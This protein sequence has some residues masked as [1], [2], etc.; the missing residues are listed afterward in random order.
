M[1]RNMDLTKGSITG[2]MLLF[3][4]PM[5]AGNLLQQCY[6]LADTFIVGRCLGPEA[7]AAVGSSYS[8]MTFLLSLVIG[9]CMGSSTLFSM[10]FGNGDIPGLKKAVFTSFLLIGVITIAVTAVTFA[11]IDPII[12]LLQVPAEVHDD[13]RD[14]L[15]IICAG[16]PFTFLYN[17]Y[18]FLLR[19]VGDSVSPLWFLG[20]SV[21]LNIGLD[22]A[23]ILGA[24]AGTAGAALATVI[25]QAFSATG[26]IWW[27]RRK[28]S[29]L[30]TSRK[31]MKTD[32]AEIKAISSYSLLTCMQ[33]S[34]MNFGILMVQG[35][36]NSFG[37]VVMAAFATAVK[38]D[39]F[40]YMPL[41]EFGNAFSTF[42]AQN[43][44][45]G[46]QERIRKGIRSAAL[47][48]TGFSVLISVATVILAP[49]L[50]GIFVGA[51][52]TEVISVGT[53]YLRIEGSFYIGIG[54]LFMLYGLF[55][56]TGRPGFSLVLTVISLGLRVL[57]SY[58]LAP[59]CGVEWIWWAIPIGWAAA[60]AAGFLRYGFP[61]RRSTVTGKAAGRKLS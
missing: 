56:A 61:G 39:A 40:A 44:G 49:M 26:L 50:M 14:Y 9:L 21:V 46:K 31:D 10:R 55:R 28:Y 42:I 47:A 27:T 6:N 4:L 11:F 43:F 7:L 58:A 22:L 53:K 12:G 33:Q 1:S 35:L 23:L 37:T 5:I 36:V 60:D 18:A 34:V 3:A 8:L 29:W 17:F 24:G 20:V 2:S 15:V 13:M 30:H 32:R 19:S 57:V 48:V 51:D 25:S 54:Y 59:S 38:I 45:A 41:Q 16:I 52:Q